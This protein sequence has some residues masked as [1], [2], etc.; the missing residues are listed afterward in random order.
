MFLTVGQNNF[1]NK[2]PIVQKSHIFGIEVYDTFYNRDYLNLKD[3][4]R[5]NLGDNLSL[6]TLSCPKLKFDYYIYL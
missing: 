1:D 3:H 4:L 5:N 2:I 6:Y